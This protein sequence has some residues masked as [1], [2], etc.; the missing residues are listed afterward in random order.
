MIRKVP[1]LL[2]VQVDLLRTAEGR[3]RVLEKA[4]MRGGF[5]QS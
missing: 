4:G 1:L 3:L 2:G 5:W